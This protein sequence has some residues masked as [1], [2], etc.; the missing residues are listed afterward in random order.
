MWLRAT[1]RSEEVSEL[2]QE[3]GLKIAVSNLGWS[4]WRNLA[5]RLQVILIELPLDASIIRETLWEAKH[6]STPIP[7]VIYD[8]ERAFDESVVTPPVSFQHVTGKLTG[9]ELRQGVFHAIEQAGRFP[10]GGTTNQE[11]WKEFLIGESRPM[12]DLHAMV[13]LVG[14]RQ[15]TVLITGETGTGKEMVARA[16]H[17]ASRRSTARMVAVNCAAIPENLVEAEL[18]GH[19]KGAFTGAMNDRIGRF[20]QAHRGTILLDEIGEIPTAV[21]AKLLRVLQEREIQRVGGTGSI[22]VDTRVI[23]ASNIDLELAVAEKR[24]RDDLLYRLNVVPIRVPALRERASDI[25]LLAAHFIDKVCSREALETK[26][27]SG[28]AMRLLTEYEWPGNVRQLEHAIEMAVTLAGDREQLYAGDFRLPE[29]RTALPTMGEEPGFRLQ[30]GSDSFDSVMA[31]VETLLLQEAL[32][33]SNG[34]K[35]KAANLLGLPRTTL[36]YK[37]K[38]LGTNA[39]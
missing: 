4:T 21:Q 9:P 2:E 10:A 3:T 35:A 25:P 1:G 12:R 20:E 30:A 28:P 23:A 22:A 29:P 17:M 32:R 16:I 33:Q 7:V 27:L 24:F 5:P 36:L 37:V 13:R 6:A 26:K 15:S 39:A 38:A 19:A 11:P 14:P 18:F 34:N 8:K 31:R